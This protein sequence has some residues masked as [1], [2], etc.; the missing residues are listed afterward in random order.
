[1]RIGEKITMQIVRLP[2]ESVSILGNS[3]FQME[4]LGT[5]RKL[6]RTSNSFV[7]ELRASEESTVLTFTFAVE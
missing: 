3:L 2:N 4:Q 5:V 7:V 6:R 1:M